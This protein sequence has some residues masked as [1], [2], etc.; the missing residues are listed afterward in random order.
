MKASSVGQSSVKSEDVGGSY[1]I[2][3]ICDN[4]LMFNVDPEDRLL[5]RGKIQ[6]TKARDNSTDNKIIYFYF[7]NTHRLLPWDRVFNGN[8]DPG[9]EADEDVVYRINQFKTQYEKEKNYEQ[10]GGLT[11][12]NVKKRSGSEQEDD[13]E[14]EES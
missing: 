10:V 2:A 9:S 5:N 7:E 6:V 12:F 14:G 3:R 1:D 4:L 11:G 13:G 8:V